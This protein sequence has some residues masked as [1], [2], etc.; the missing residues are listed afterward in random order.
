M[1]LVR[2]LSD[3]TVLRFLTTFGDLWQLLVGA[4]RFSRRGWEW[5]NDLNDLS[6]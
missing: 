6:T 5:A 3:F 4:R 2:W 1:I